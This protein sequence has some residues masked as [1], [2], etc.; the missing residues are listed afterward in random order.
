MRME[1]NELFLPL[2][3]SQPAAWLGMV[4]TEQDWR[5]G[6]NNIKVDD[7]IRVVLRKYCGPTEKENQGRLPGG[8]GI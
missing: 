8:T 5:G 1:R 6:R 4:G 2:K 3:S 7:S